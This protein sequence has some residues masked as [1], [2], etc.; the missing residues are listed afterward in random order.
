MAV[1]DCTQS[2]LE[3]RLFTIK[4]LTKEIGGTDWFW[5]SQIWDG[6]LP[7]VQ[8]GRKMFVDRNDIESFIQRNKTQY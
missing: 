6:K 2:G 7:F 1:A 5:R 3:K 4:E 8:V